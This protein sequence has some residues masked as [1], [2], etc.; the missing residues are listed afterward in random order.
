MIMTPS[1]PMRSASRAQATASRVHSAPVP[2]STGTR[3]ARRPARRSRSP[4][5]AP[6][7][8]STEI[9]RCCRAGSGRG[10]P[11][12]LPVHQPLQCRDIDGIPVGGEGGDQD[13]VGAA[14]RHGVICRSDLS[15]T[16]RIL[17]YTYSAIGFPRL[18]AARSRSL[19]APRS[20]IRFIACGDAR[21]HHL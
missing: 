10:C 6:P 4:Q 3:P 20:S 12:D 13:R 21:R 9:R 16:Y 19:H 8:S 2:I 11:L 5:C 15:D 1:A 7:A 17:T 18:F 14:Q